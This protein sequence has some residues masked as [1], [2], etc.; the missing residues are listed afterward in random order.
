MSRSREKRRRKNIQIPHDC[1]DYDYNN[2]ELSDWEETLFLEIPCER[3]L[4]DNKNK[5]KTRYYSRGEAKIA[6]Q[7]AEIEKEYVERQKKWR[8]E[9]TKERKARKIEK[10]NTMSADDRALIKNNHAPLN[11]SKPRIIMLYG[12]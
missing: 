5:R 2:A 11:E 12:Y 8:E 1:S 6:K 10:R 3:K 7:N 9:Y 4:E